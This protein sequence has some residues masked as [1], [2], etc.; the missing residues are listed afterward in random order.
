MYEDSDSKIFYTML[1]FVSIN[2]LQ[3]KLKTFKYRGKDIHGV[4]RS[5]FHFFCPEQTLIFP[6]FI[7]WCASNYSSSERVI[8]DVAKSKICYIFNIKIA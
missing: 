6:N 5:H 2:Q 7:E 4:Y 1:S 3:T 8:M